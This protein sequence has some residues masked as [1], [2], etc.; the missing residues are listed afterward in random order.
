MTNSARPETLN[1]LLQGDLL[2]GEW[3]SE[4][5]RRGSGQ[6]IRLKSPGGERG[7]LPAW[8][9][10]RRKTGGHVLSGL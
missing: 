9:T 4:S 2:S 3:R 8:R 5:P 7:S 1:G 6:Y 10:F